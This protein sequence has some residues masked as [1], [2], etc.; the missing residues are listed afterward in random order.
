MFSYK[1][2]PATLEKFTAETEGNY[3]AKYT[4]LMPEYADSCT[5]VQECEHKNEIAVGDTVIQAVVFEKAGFTIA[6]WKQ[7]PEGSPPLQ[8][9]VLKTFKAV[10]RSINEIPRT[11]SGVSASSR[12]RVSVALCLLFLG[13][14]H[15]QE[16]PFQRIPHSTHN[17]LVT[18][19][20]LC[21]RTYAG[22]KEIL[23]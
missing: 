14:S 17:S 18:T 1:E 16:F 10:V 4:V 22:E 23:L 15:T 13:R 5:L 6:T 21:R 3:T 7:L 9:H 12:V 19:Y 11:E 20:L 2:L 8:G